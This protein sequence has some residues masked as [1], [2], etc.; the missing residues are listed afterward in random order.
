MVPCRPQGG[1][2]LDASRAVC[3]TLEETVKELREQLR[4]RE[5]LEAE[6]ETCKNQVGTHWAGRNYNHNQS[7][8]SHF[9]LPESSEGLSN[10][11]P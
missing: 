4:K 1:G 7:M 10:C 3:D 2:G 9:L 8:W 6:L 11:L 5:Q